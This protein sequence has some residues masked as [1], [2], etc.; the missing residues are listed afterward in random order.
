MSDEASAIFNFTL[1]E[2]LS[3]IQY[4]TR[5]LT[6]YIELDKEGEKYKD[7]NHKNKYMPLIA[8]IHSK[9][10][11]LHFWDEDYYSATLEY[12]AAIETLPDNK[13][14]ES[15]FLTRI[16]CMLKLGLAYELRKLYPNAY[17]TYCR[18][19]N[20][21]IKK[22]W[23]NE[24]DFGLS[25]MDARVQGW[26]DKRQVLIKDSKPSENLTSENKFEKQFKRPIFDGNYNNPDIG[27]NVYSLNFDGIITTFARDL[28]VEKTQT[29]NTLTLF[30]EIRYLYQSILLLYCL[31]YI[32]QL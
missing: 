21:L 5:L 26:Q 18:L 1:D 2:S 25:V 20:L 13:E 22:R 17:Q 12:R 10:G 24:A 8:R 15:G 16:R 27:K 11:D 28:T 9:L 14:D 32:N 23:V 29:I 3:V 6:Y 4:N 31:Y 19:I 30:E 7:N